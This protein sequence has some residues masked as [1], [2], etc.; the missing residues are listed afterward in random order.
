VNFKM[1][2]KEEITD[3]MIEK[4]FDELLVLYKRYE[5]EDLD[6]VA[7][8]MCMDIAYLGGS[9]LFESVGIL[10]EAI[11]NLREAVLNGDDKDCMCDDC[12]EK[13]EKEEEKENKENDEDDEQ[14]NKNNIN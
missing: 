9:S 12:R 2:H 7:M 1:T 13:M 4:K 10:Q 6:L 3:K 14:G 5:G 11:S 8:N